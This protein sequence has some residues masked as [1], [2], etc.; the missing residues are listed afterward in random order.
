MIIP[1]KGMN[2][3]FNTL[4][5]YIIYTNRVTLRDVLCERG[6]KNNGRKINENRGNGLAGI[7]GSLAKTIKIQDCIATEKNK[8][9]T[10]S[11]RGSRRVLDRL[12]VKTEETG[13]KPC[14][15]SVSAWAA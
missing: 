9:L 5:N 10:L 1:N 15:R 11:K 7:R 4:E 14:K 8:M 6:T 13:S 12:L 2:H 3:L